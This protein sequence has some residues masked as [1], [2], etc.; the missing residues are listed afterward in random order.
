MHVTP[1]GKLAV[2][3]GNLKVFIPCT[4]EPF[5]TNAPEGERMIAPTGFVDALRL[6]A[7]FVSKDNHHTW[8]TGILFKGLSLFATSNIVVV[9]KFVGGKEVK[10]AV[11]IPIPAV[12]EILRIK[13]EPEE[14][15]TSK[16]SATF[17][18]S[19]G[20]W[21]KTQLITGDWPCMDG[22]LDGLDNA[23]NTQA[24]EDA[25]FF[26]AL[27]ELIP[28]TDSSSRVFLHP[29]RIST[30]AEKDEGAIIE[31]SVTGGQGIYNARALLSIEKIAEEI[32]L[33]KYPKPAFFKGNSLRGAISGMRL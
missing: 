6:L 12:K 8:A 3:Y 31:V 1:K 14:I 13:E 16:N 20:R 30:T 18:Y 29:S 26:S 17:L 19:G 10:D 28:F 21:L 22:F 27:K 11:I 5:P 33:S 9:Q 7:P 23:A 24:I 25:T 2:I 15:L 4:D 32:D